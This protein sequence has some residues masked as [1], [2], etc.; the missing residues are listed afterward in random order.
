MLKGANY[1]VAEPVRIDRFLGRFELRSAYGTF[2]VSG[3]DMLAARVREIRAIEE[4]QKVES[5]STFTEALAKSASSS[6]K[7]VGS[8]VTDPGKTV[9][10]IAAGARCLDGSAIRSNQAFRTLGT[11]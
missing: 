9:E 8:L 3:V 10:N 11:L 7:L 6:V 5:S 2:G 4:L 1:D